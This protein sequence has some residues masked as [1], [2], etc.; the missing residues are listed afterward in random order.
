MKFGLLAQVLGITICLGGKVNFLSVQSAQAGVPVWGSASTIPDNT[1]GNERSILIP[2]NSR[3]DHIG[4]GAQRGSALFHSFLEFNIPEGRAVYFDNPPGTSI[5]L[6]RV[7]GNNPSHLFG[8]LGVLGDADLIFINPNDIVLGPN[9]HSDMKGS[10]LASTADGIQ[11]P[12]GNQFSATNPQSFSLLDIDFDVRIGLVFEGGPPAAI[13]NQA[14]ANRNS[15]AS[16]PLQVGPEQNLA[17]L[18]GEVLFEGSRVFSKGGSVEIGAVAEGT[19]TLN[20]TETGWNLGYEGVESFSDIQLSKEAQIDTEGGE[21]QLQ[22]RQILLVDGSPIISHNPGLEAGKDVIIRAKEKVVISGTSVDGQVPSGLLSITSGIGSGGNLLIETEELEVTNGGTVAAVTFGPG[23]GGDLMIYANKSVKLSGT[24]FGDF[25]QTYLEFPLAGTVGLQDG[26]NGLISGSSSSGSGGDTVIETG[27]L[28]LENGAVVWNIAFDEGSGGNIIIRA[29]D[30]V[31]LEQA[32]LITGTALAQK[33][34]A[35]NIDIN[36]L[37]LNINEG[38]IIISATLGEGNSGN[39][40][41]NASESIE[42]LRTQ[43]AAEQLIGTGIFVNTTFGSGKGGQLSIETGKLIIHDG[44]VIVNNSGAS[45]PSAVIALG[46]QGGDLTIKADYIEIVGTSAN[47]KVSSGFGTTTFTDN[48][49]GNLSIATAKLVIGDGARITTATLGSGKAGTLT[50]NATES[51]EL[52]GTSDDSSLPSGSVATSGR[53][54]LP[55]L[56]VTGASGD[57]AIFTGQLIIK[58]GAEVSV[59]SLDSGDEAGEIE[60]VARTIELDD[61]SIKAEARSGEGG[62]I[63]LQVQDSLVLRNGSKVSATAGTARSGGDGGNIVI[64]AG[65]GFIIAFPGE[66]SEIAA[67]AFIGDGGSIKIK[68]LGILG[69]DESKITA[70]SERGVDGEVN[71]DLFG[72]NPGE[73]PLNQLE[74]LVDVELIEGCQV[75]RR[76]ES[77]QFSYVGE[78]GSPPAPE[79]VSVTKVG[80]WLSL[81]R[82]ENDSE[83]AVSGNTFNVDEDVEGDNTVLQSETVASTLH[84]NSCRTFK[85]HIWKPKPQQRLEIFKQIDLSIF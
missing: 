46:G 5:I 78:G 70:I 69:I 60:V 84:S 47:G 44:G 14:G 13:I 74:Q 41:V 22:G 26:K 64:D 6:S 11:L 7:T 66:D 10:F 40:S 4:G 51:V 33:G 39:V 25:Q 76:G 55:E 54:D 45:L 29:S 59:A 63:R 2:I 21:I 65:E 71:I 52:E 72:N 30:S 42:I 80:S 9:F 56:V 35:G 50:I 81:P 68:V 28:T 49:A 58:D 16:L 61:G 17:F 15:E 67:N 38:G 24:G 27:K 57:I 62:N 82:S 34:D 53:T 75:S 23:R 83:Q 8:T 79:D 1:L 77:A 31:E 85:K 36:T 18:G 73:E 48:N 12:G 20:P 43:S 19:V 3:V 37:Q 32:G